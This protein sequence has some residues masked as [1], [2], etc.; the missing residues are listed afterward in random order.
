MFYE[1][2]VRPKVVL[3]VD[4]GDSVKEF[5]VGTLEFVNDD[6]Q[7]GDKIVQGNSG[8]WLEILMHLGPHV[9][10]VVPRVQSYFVYS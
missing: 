6:K 2:E 10:W 5:A 3:L 4:L 9:L 8:L 7:I 1:N